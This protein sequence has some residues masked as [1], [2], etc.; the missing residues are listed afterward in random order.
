MGWRVSSAMLLKRAYFTRLNHETRVSSGKT[1]PLLFEIT[2][3][4]FIY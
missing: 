3:R 1:K 4:G 2:R